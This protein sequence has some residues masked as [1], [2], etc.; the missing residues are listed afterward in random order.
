MRSLWISIVL[1][2][3]MP[4]LASAGDLGLAGGISGAGKAMGDSLAAMQSGLIMQQMMEQQAYFQREQDERAYQ[5]Q[6]ERDAATHQR[7]ME[8]QRAALRSQGDIE[9]ERTRVLQQEA[10]GQLT[11]THPDWKAV[12]DDTRYR[13]WLAAQP[14]TY[15]QLINDSWDPL[16]IGASIDQFRM[17]KGLEARK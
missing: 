10:V 8:Y 5:A 17:G 14:A 4:G 11:R 1:V 2:C 6:R 15:Q 9:A 16:V 7:Q 13:Q 3:G 12:V